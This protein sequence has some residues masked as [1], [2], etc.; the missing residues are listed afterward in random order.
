MYI[1]ALNIDHGS[2]KRGWITPGLVLWLRTLA[3]A[4]GMLILARAVYLISYPEYFAT[5]RTTDV[6]FAFLVGLR[7]DLATALLT[8]AVPTL[9]LWVPW[10]RKAERIAVQFTAILT[11]CFLA[12]V[13]GFLWSDLLFFGE[14]SRHF[15]V[16][17]AGIGDDILP[18]LMTVAHD[19]TWQLLGLLAFLTILF[20]AVKRYLSPAAVMRRS[21]PAIIVYIV[22]FVLV[23]GTSILGIRGGLQKEPLKSA[24]AMRAG[25]MSAAALALNGWYSFLETAVFDQRPPQSPLKEADAVATVRGLI[26]AGHS[27]F[28]EPRFPVKRMLSPAASV[29]APGESLNVVL[30]I[31][32]SLNAS[33]LESF[34]GKPGVMPFL[35]SLA[36]ESRIFTNCQSLGTRSFRGVSAIVTS[37]PNLFGNP[38]AITISL[39]R[40]RGLGD[41]LAEQGYK[42]RFMHAAAPGSMGISAICRMA[43]YNDFVTADDF[44]ESA[45][46]GSWGVWDH[47]ALERM[48]KDMEALPEPFHYGIFTLSTHSPWRLPE[49]YT[50]TVAASAPEADVLNTFGYLD[51]AL[52]RFFEHEARQPRFERTLYVI[53]GDHT[54]HAQENDRFRVACLYYAPGR[55]A[56][57]SDSRVVSHLDVL[58]SILDL[59]GIHAS[60]A[61]FGRSMF[62]PDSTAGS[63]IMTQSDM[64]YW[65][66]GNR[67]FVSNVLRDLGLYDARDLSRNLL[68]SEPETTAKMRRELLS[69][70]QVAE[71]SLR[72]NRV[73]GN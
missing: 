55:M 69:F 58:P 16:E 52:R 42:V 37:V 17:P 23:V 1:H 65:R 11:G 36:H 8:I 38:Y 56:P 22:S 53:V 51:S 24:D 64:L 40:L 14:S 61:P 54:A 41:V 50:P 63:A 10:P 31:V 67:I 12:V 15:T 26:G 2:R 70:Y 29:A 27:E 18:M 48:S 73:Y 9:P 7:F 6:V 71:Q 62:Q 33:W 57:G 45:F 60:G 46:D 72:E 35:D 39:P 21:R 34:G 47:L 44:P 43:G 5:L 4:V 68:G 13:A 49:S 30:L 28:R 25:Q 66:S 59:A 32:E 19:Y 20:F 3:L